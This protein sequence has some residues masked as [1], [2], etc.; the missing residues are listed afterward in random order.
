MATKA[1]KIMSRGVGPSKLHRDPN[2]PDPYLHL[3][4]LHVGGVQIEQLPEE[5]V[6][7]LSYA[8]TDE[9]IEQRNAGKADTAVHV[10]GA[11]GD[12]APVTGADFDRHLEERRDFREDGSELWEA[13]DL[14]K[15]L[16]EK[17][18][19]P[20]M[21]PKFLSP[22]QIDKR[23]LRG[24]EI[25]KDSTGQPVKVG[26]MMLG[27]MPEAKAR[28]RK[29]HFRKKGSERLAAIEQENTERQRELVG[30]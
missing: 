6:A 3:R 26:R 22:M 29:E 16:A 28:A 23:G 14:M 1:K 19:A 2:A 9:A 17:Y 18:V 24:Y 30:R 27:Q 20:G 21:A 25:V 13:P 4:G 8:H 10:R 7:R 11:A 12:R 15:E 5:M